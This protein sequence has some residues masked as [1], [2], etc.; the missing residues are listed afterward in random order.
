[1][2]E[3]LRVL[4][5]TSVNC[6]APAMFE[7]KSSPSSNIPFL[8]QLSLIYLDD[9]IARYRKTAIETSTGHRSDK[10]RSPMPGGGFLNRI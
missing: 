2:P 7:T 8:T 3:L 10:V 4:S 6:T 9:L 5:A 1:V